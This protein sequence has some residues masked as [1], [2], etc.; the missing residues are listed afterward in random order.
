MLLG[1][2]RTLLGHHRHPLSPPAPGPQ[3]P[4]GHA[5][6]RRSETKVQG[7][8]RGGQ[9]WQEQFIGS[10]GT[11]S[12]GTCERGSGDANPA[13]PGGSDGHERAQSHL[14]RSLQRCRAARTR[15]PVSD[16]PPA[17]RLHPRQSTGAL[18]T[19]CSRSTTSQSRGHAGAS[20]GTGWSRSAP[21]QHPA[22]TTT[23]QST[24]FSRKTKVC[25]Q[26]SR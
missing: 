24:L 15:R 23:S 3:C 11:K 25:F 10:P 19:H 21:Q 1:K 14:P 20:P 5:R 12:L 17:L 16:K 7:A 9:A 4:P 26:P 18:L 2:G 13:R 22:T 6:P 8:A